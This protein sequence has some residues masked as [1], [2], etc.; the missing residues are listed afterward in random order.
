MS[1]IPSGLKKEINNRYKEIINDIGRIVYIYS[2]PE[3]Q[4]CPNCFSSPSTGTSIK[5]FDSSFITPVEIF[6]NIISPLSF[7]RGR[8][9]VCKDEGVLKQDVRK[10]IKSIV[11]WN[12]GSDDGKII[13]LP[14]GREGSNIVSIKTSK[15]HYNTIRDCIYAM[16]DGVKCELVEP[17]VFR[18][19]QYTDIVVIAYFVSV[20][21][22]K[23]VRG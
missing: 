6:G 19:L 10:G 15:C 2:T 3:T 17:P 4:D 22:G 16:I 1:I 8:C 9:P 14:A 7:T 12:P 5:S 21:T 18:N 20:D 23:S 13:Q 11:R